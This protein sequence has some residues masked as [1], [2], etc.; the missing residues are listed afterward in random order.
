MHLRRRSAKAAAFPPADPRG[1][2]QEHPRPHSKLLAIPRVGVRSMLSLN[3]N[4]LQ[5][6]PQS[7]LVMWR[8][9]PPDAGA[10]A[11]RQSRSLCAQPALLPPAVHEGL[12]SPPAAWLALRAAPTAGD[13]VR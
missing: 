7:P 6:P 1:D 8:T 13:A 10:R 11:A 3:S 5:Q 9:C 4:I 2:L 12:R